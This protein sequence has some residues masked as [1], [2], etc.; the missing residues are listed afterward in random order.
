MATLVGEPSYE[1]PVSDST[2]PTAGI[3]TDAFIAAFTSAT[4]TSS[5]R[6]TAST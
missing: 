2:R 5:A 3:Y 4:G 1:V 6:W